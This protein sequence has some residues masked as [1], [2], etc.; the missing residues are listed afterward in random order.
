VS[1]QETLYRVQELDTRILELRGCE[2][3]HPLQ[4]EIEALREGREKGLA[5]SEQ[6][7]ANLEESRKKQRGLEDEVQG[8]EEK[9]GREEEKL[10]GGK[11][12]NPKELRGL[13]AEVRSLKHKKD[14]LETRLLEEMENLDEITRKADELQG[15]RDRLQAEID[16]KAGVLDGE[17]AEIRAELAGLE[18]RRRELRS[19]VD[20]EL[21]EL[22][23][24][25][26]ESKHGLAVVKVSDGVCL[27]CRVELPGIEFDRFLKTE[28]AFTC[29]N[30]GRILAK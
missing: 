27:G 4:A 8:V 23:D 14:I 1:Q 22:Y 6:T 25:L 17:I 29:T 16:E 19:Q 30:C 10:Y 26:L 20:E 12:N 24:E 5:E 15:E 18:E 11:V 3:N 21:L 2:G 28:S 7:V 13:Q 9:L